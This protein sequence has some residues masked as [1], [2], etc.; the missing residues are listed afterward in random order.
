MRNEKLS[1]EHKAL[2]ADRLKK[3]NVPLSEYSFANLYLF[4]KAHDYEL[5]F[6]DEHVFVKG[7]TYN[8]ATFLMPTQPPQST[9]FDL[10]KQL[11][12][13]VDFLFPIPETWLVH[14]PTDRFEFHYD[15]ADTDYVYT[16]EKMATFK[17]RRLSKKRNLLKQFLAQYSPQPTRLSFKRI[18][19]AIEILEHWQRDVDLPPAETDYEACLEALKMYDQLPICGVIYYVNREPAGFILAEELTDEMLVLHFAKGEKRFKGLYQ[20][21][22]NTFA[23]EL[24][25]HYDQLNFEQ[26]LGKLALRIAKS[27][28][29]PDAMLKKYRVKFK[30]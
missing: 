24:P 27:S 18:A 22:Y 17:G 15:E 25:H 10:L 13:T 9:H 12:A 26:D 7:K 21:M 2:L 20:Y 5:L 4:R 14:F 3:A 30:K 16:V 8:N 19:D 11:L 29:V 1:F 28:Y 6:D 23:K